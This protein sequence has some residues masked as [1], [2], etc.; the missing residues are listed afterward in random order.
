MWSVEDVT[1]LEDFEVLPENILMNFQGGEYE[2]N[3]FVEGIKNY[4]L[5]LFGINDS[6]KN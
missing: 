4:V 6:N 2:G 5:G 3:R 1:R